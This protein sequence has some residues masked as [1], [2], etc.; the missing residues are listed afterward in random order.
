M[1]EFFKN[2]MEPCRVGVQLLKFSL[3][4]GKALSKR[5][6]A[7]S[8]FTKIGHQTAKVGHHLWNIPSHTGKTLHPPGGVPQPLVR[9][10]GIFEKLD[11]KP[12]R[13]DTKPMSLDTFSVKHCPTLQ[14]SET[15]FACFGREMLFLIEK[16]VVSPTFWSY[17]ILS[18]NTNWYEYTNYECC[19]VRQATEG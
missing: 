14:R 2:A 5:V 8:C 17:K 13:L 18:T 9:H 1:R 11:T 4:H 16:S 19:Y 7:V 10:E 12:G 6:K 3:L 15:I